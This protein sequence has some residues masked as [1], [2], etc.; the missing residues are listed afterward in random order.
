MA[1]IALSDPN[2]LFPSR[3]LWAAFLLGLDWPAAAWSSAAAP[4]A[5]TW[6]T[7]RPFGPSLLGKS[8][9]AWCMIDWDSTESSHRQ[10]THFESQQSSGR[11]S[12]MRAT[13]SITSAILA[14]PSCCLLTEGGENV[15]FFSSQPRSAEAS[16]KFSSFKKLCIT[17]KLWDSGINTNCINICSA[18]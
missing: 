9:S 14:M 16:N 11:N 1:A 7:D 8:R 12:L 13:L 17:Q 6:G 2:K 10:I 4:R 15:F 3:E 18:D 5:W